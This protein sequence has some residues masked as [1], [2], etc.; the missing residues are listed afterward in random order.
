MGREAVCAASTDIAATAS[1][2]GWVP[3][4]GGNPLG[5]TQRLSLEKRVMA[6]PSGFE[7]HKREP[8]L[9]SGLGGVTHTPVRLPAL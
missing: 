6:T 3:S 2:T 4:M 1:K 9:V 8:G 5:L 7:P